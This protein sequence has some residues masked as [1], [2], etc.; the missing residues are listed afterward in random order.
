[1]PICNF[2]FHIYICMSSL[3]VINDNLS[4]CPSFSFWFTY[5][6]GLS[7]TSLYMLDSLCGLLCIIYAQLYLWFL[8]L[9]FFFVYGLFLPEINT[10]L[11]HNSFGYMYI[12][13]QI[14]CIL[15]GS[16]MVF[17][18][19]YSILVSVCL[20][21][22]VCIYCCVRFKIEFCMCVFIVGQ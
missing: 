6:Q 18:C 10:N 2:S 17:I 19:M 11:S 7:T 16:F 12:M 21:A 14:Y 4:I 9:S 13:H 1:M 15:I 3:Y 8:D 22:C 5:L 20:C